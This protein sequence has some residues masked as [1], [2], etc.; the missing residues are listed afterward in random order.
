[1]AVT[2]PISCFS[3]QVNIITLSDIFYN[4]L[5]LF[6]CKN[7]YFFYTIIYLDGSGMD[8]RTMLKKKK[9]AKHM[10]EDQ[11]PDWGNLKHVEKEEPEPE[12]V[13]KE[14]MYILNGDIYF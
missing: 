9:Y 7:T 5:I 11:D 14:V 10:V 1:M 4:L 6:L 8:F 2:L 13:V 3:S 12:P